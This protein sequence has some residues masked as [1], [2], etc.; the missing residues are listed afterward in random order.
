[1]YVDTPVSVQNRSDLYAET[2]TDLPPEGI[3]DAELVRVEVFANPFGERVGLVFRLD[4]GTTLM[5]SAAPGSPKGK[6]AEFLNPLGGMEGTAKAARAA[7]GRRC[8][9]AVRHGVNKSGKR[10]AAVAHT[11]GPGI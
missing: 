3:H 2:A 11:Y 6:L 9:I 10:F 4:D 5:Q 1:M 8:R 7:I